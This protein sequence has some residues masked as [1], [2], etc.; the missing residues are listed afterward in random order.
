MR[1]PGLLLLAGAFWMASRFIAPALP[2]AIVIAAGSPGG[3][4][5]AVGARYAQALA[6]SGIKVV[7]RPTAG[8]VENARLKTGHGSPVDAALWQGGHRRV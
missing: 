4:S 8:S 7:L 2:K 3:V 5:H 6:D 1:L